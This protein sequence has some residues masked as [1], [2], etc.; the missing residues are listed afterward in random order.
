MGHYR[1]EEWGRIEYNAGSDEF[2]AYLTSGDIRA[3]SRRPISA[4]VLITGKC[5]LR[6]AFCYGND[7]SL[8]RTEID[9]DHWTRIS[10]IKVDGVTLADRVDGRLFRLV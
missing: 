3:E 5:N 10:G 8:P 9:L 6:C 2:E 1:R 4:G 7:E